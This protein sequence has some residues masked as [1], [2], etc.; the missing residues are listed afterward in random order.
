ML[1][2]SPGTFYNNKIVLQ[3]YIRRQLNEDVLCSMVHCSMQVCHIDINV[4]SQA[5]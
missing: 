2:G 5:A 1:I 4:L 3:Y